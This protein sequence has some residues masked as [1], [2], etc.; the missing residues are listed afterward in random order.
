MFRLIMDHK[1]DVAFKY[2]HQERVKVYKGKKFEDFY[3]Q[4]SIR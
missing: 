3:G 1:D 4:K 2:Q